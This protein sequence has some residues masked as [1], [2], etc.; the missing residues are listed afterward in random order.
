MTAFSTAGLYF[1]FLGLGAAPKEEK[2]IRAAMSS[3][4]AEGSASMLV[5]GFEWYVQNISRINNEI[6]RP[7]KSHRAGEGGER[8][9]L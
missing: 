3:E 8:V 9:R 4:G 2:P 5:V 1:R 7:E 6:S